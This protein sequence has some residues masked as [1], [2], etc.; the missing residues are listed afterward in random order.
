M[1]EY[2][3]FRRVIVNNKIRMGYM[4]ASKAQSIIFNNQ[5]VLLITAANRRRLQ[6]YTA[7]GIMLQKMK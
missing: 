5:E 6:H 4:T 1:S 2:Y 3:T 7:L